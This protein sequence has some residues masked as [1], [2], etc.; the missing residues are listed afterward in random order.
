MNN[1]GKTEQKATTKD[2]KVV[3]KG[4]DINMFVEVDFLDAVQGVLKSVSY[5]RL[6]VCTTCKGSKSKPGSQVYPCE[7]CGGE[8]HQSVLQGSNIL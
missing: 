4:K 3:I 7:H 1:K 8:G 5:A 2:K 6:T